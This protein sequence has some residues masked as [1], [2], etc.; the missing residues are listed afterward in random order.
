MAPKPSVKPAPLLSECIDPYIQL[1]IQ[2]K[3]VEG[4][5][6]V[7]ECCPE[8]GIGRRVLPVARKLQSL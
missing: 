4:R 1:N 5:L 3:R 7:P 6:S 2:L 8:L